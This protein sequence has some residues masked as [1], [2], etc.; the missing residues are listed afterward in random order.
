MATATEHYSGTSRRGYS[1]KISR[2][3]RSYQDII[4]LL[5]RSGV[6]MTPTIGIFDF[7]LAAVDEPAYIEDERFG[8]LF[9]A[10]LVVRTQNAV[11]RSR[12]KRAERVAQS[13]ASRQDGE[14]HP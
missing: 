14:G 12:E 5:A 3:L 4:E 9:P 11:A 10:S 6:T 13:R 1:S 8:T 2:T 7:A